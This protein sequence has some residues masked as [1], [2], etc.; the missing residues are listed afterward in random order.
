MAKTKTPAALPVDDALIRLQ[1]ARTRAEATHRENKEREA[2]LAGQFLHLKAV[3]DRLTRRRENLQAAGEENPGES[4]QAAELA[5]TAS[6]LRDG[7]NR[8]LDTL[9]ELLSA[10]ADKSRDSEE[11]MERIDAAAVRLQDAIRSLGLARLE[12]ENRERLANLERTSM[13]SLQQLGRVNTQARP[14]VPVPPEAADP[15][16]DDYVR[17]VTRLTY[18]A[19][20]LADLLRES[21]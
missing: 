2:S 15:G 6:R 21:A 1:E 3:V 20:A 16:L 10:A 18:E 5:A 4:R 12:R 17:E 9:R 14:G 7:A 13:A 8:S 19:E 11:L